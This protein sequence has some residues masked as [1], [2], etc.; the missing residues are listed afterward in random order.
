MQPIT[1]E[2]LFKGG[3]RDHEKWVE[4][5][6]RTVMRTQKGMASRLSE[7]RELMMEIKAALATRRF[8]R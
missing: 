3:K 1:E 8:S 4:D 6:F 2:W 5:N 7:T